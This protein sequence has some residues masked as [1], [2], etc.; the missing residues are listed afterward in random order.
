MGAFMN[1]RKNQEVRNQ[2]HKDE[3]ANSKVEESSTSKSYQ[4]TPIVSFKITYSVVKRTL[5][6][7]RLNEGNS[8]IRN[9]EEEVS[10]SGIFE[11]QKRR[12]T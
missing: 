10:S 5:E 11:R 8:C 6:N 7:S 9:C 1:F 2:L 12:E 3:G 4:R